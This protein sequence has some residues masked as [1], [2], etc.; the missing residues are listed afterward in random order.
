M[1]LKNGDC[2]AAIVAGANLITSI[3]QH[4]GTM[5]GGVLSPTSTCHTF[6]ASADGYGRGEAVNAVLIKPLSRAIRDGDN[7]RAIIRGTAMLTRGLNSQCQRPTNGITQPSARFQEA[8]IRKLT[9]NAGLNM[10]T[11]I[12]L[13]VM[14]PAPPLGSVEV[15]GIGRCF[16]PRYGPPLMIG[17]IKTNVGHS[18]AASA[19]TRM[20]VFLRC[21]EAYYV[22]V[23]LDKCNLQVVDELSEWPRELRRASI[24]SFGYGGANA[25]V[26]LEDPKSFLKDNISSPDDV[27]LFPI[28]ARSKWSLEKRIEQ[29][30]DYV[31]SV[32]TTNELSSI[33]FTLGEHRAHLSHRAFIIANHGRA[34]DA[35]MASGKDIDALPLAFVFTGQ[36]AQYPGMGKE[37]L[38][39]EVVF[40]DSIK[41]LDAVLQAIPWRD[42]RPS[43]TLEQTILDPPETSMIHDVTRSQP[44]CTAIQI[45]LVDLLDSWGIQAREDLR[46]SLLASEPESTVQFSGALSSLTAERKMRVIEIG[47]HAALKGPIEM[48]RKKT[49]HHFHYSPSLVRDQDSH[50]CSKKL[51]GRF[52]YSWVLL[53][54]DSINTALCGIKPPLS[55]LPLTH[56]IILGHFYGVSHEPALNS[57]TVNIYAMNF[58]EYCKQPK[59]HRL[60]VAE[61]ASA[62]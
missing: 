7:I 32:S 57:V 24:N 19:W 14:E 27:Y 62:I 29:V 52:V 33:A 17:A 5:K 48:I 42:Q 10:Q 1:A 39:R 20:K 23:Q 8:V 54:W 37:L 61:S 26:I 38:K 18:E 56:G 44:V 36:G 50:K 47:P 28:S 9:P 6:D 31:N 58:L 41:E 30:K 22:L 45:A 13:N 40:R 53:E 59:R 2:S 25:H 21:N 3:E 49:G 34:E 55:T 4:L 46:G 60:G 16:S 11:L 35:V 15:E 51:A 43:W 12:T